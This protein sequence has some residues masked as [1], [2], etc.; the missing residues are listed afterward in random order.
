MYAYRQGDV[1]ITP[2]PVPSEAEETK[3]IVLAEGELTGHAHRIG[4]GKAKLFILPNKSMVFVRV[5]EPTTITHEEHH[6]IMLPMG[7]YKVDIQREYDWFS[8]EIRKVAD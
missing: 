5:Y 3:G 7:D 6:D 2:M 4:N 1:V 8:E